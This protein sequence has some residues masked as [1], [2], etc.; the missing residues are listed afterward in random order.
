MYAQA[1]THRQTDPPKH[2]WLAHS[3]HSGETDR[4]RARRRRD[5]AYS[6]LGVQEVQVAH[7]VY[8]VCRT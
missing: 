6:Q 5:C 8:V 1:Q 4:Q 2:S 7:I 3:R